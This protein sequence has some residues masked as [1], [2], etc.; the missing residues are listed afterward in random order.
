MTSDPK[1]QGARGLSAFIVPGDAK[2]L[3]IAERLEVIAP[4]P[5]ARLRFDGCR[6]PASAMIGS[7][8]EGFKI[9]MATLDVFRALRSAPQLSA[10][11]AA[12]STRL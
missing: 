2:G 5:L 12:R 1:S 4:H 9:A 7:A 11:P 10:S 6:V 3:H 8:G